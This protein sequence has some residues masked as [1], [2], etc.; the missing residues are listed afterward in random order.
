[1]PRRLL[2]IGIGWAWAAA[3]V[4]LSLTP[5]PP[6]LAFAASDKLGHFLAY[7]VLMIW[8]CSLY[9]ST[10][11]R[12]VFG[13]AFVAMGVGLELVQGSLGTRTY[14]RADMLANALGVATGW[15]IAVILPRALQAAGKGTRSAGR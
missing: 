12:L 6:S 15:A 11:A 14:E 5:A 9:R 8:F 7:G 13:L 10:R 1:M 3:V 4:W 2:L